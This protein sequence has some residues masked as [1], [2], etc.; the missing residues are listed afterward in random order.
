MNKNAGLANLLKTK[1]NPMIEIFINL[2]LTFGVAQHGNTVHIDDYT[3]REIEKISGFKTE[4]LES[5][6]DFR[7]LHINDGLLI[8]GTE[9]NGSGK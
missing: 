5:N 4:L 6:K 7:I 1:T 9:Q 3:V 8:V 2:A